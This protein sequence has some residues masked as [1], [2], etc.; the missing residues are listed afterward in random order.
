MLNEDVKVHI[1]EYLNDDFSAEPSFG[2]TAEGLRYR[3]ESSHEL[4]PFVLAHVKKSA[5]KL[6]AELRRD[7]EAS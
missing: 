2:I 6:L 4:S 1:A 5:S 7:A 3:M